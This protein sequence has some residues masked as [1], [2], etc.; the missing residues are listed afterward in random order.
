MLIDEIENNKC[1]NHI[2]G[3]NLK[4]TKYEFDRYMC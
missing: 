2:F 3:T 1:T 4:L